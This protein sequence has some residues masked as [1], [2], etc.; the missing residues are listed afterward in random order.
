MIDELF[1]ARKYFETSYSLAKDRDWD[2]FQIDNHF[3]RY[4]LLEAVE[5]NDTKQA[6]D[7]F[8]KA[9]VII[10]RQ[11]RNE[12]IHY[13]YKVAI[14]YW[15]FYNRYSSYFTEGLLIQIKQAAD[16]VL[17]RIVQLQ[18]YRRMHRNVR[19][20]KNAME[21]ILDSIKEIQEKSESDHEPTE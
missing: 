17:K 3:A 10:D 13:P 9:R 8:R 21:R 20:C 2:T 19:D 1:R 12:R 6:I 7:N 4:L 5:L 15:D 14:L 11:M 16:E 18:K